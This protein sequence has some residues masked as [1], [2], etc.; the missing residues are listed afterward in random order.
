MKRDYPER[1]L[2][3]VGAAIVRNEQILVVRRANPPLQGQWSIPGGLVDTGET[4]KEAVVREIR[5]ETSLTIEPIE[6]IEVFE[7][8]L[9]DAE[10]RVQY[11]FVVIDYL[12]RLLWG[13]PR[14]STDVSEIRWARLEELPML[15]ITPET[16]AVIQ[17]AL[18]AAKKLTAFQ[19]GS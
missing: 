7:R 18:S 12:C 6:L 9:R 19:T 8:I 4:T 3:G 5:E 2:L 15:G 10:S 16:T 17:K 11:H 13:E 1:P 14:P